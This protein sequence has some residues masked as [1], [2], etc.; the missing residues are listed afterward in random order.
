MR[1]HRARLVKVLPLVL[2]FVFAWLYK[3]IAG[4][5]NVIRFNVSV[6]VRVKKLREDHSHD[7]KCQSIRLRL[8]KGDRS[9]C[10]YDDDYRSQH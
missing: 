5:V 10:D 9:D 4:Q 2:I 3:L 8:W 6:R 1:K 7:T